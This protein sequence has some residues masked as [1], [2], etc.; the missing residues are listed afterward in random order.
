MGN[1]SSVAIPTARQLYFSPL[2]RDVRSQEQL[3]TNFFASVKLSNGTYKY[4]YSNR[5]DDLNALVNPLLPNVRPLKIMDVAISSG[6]ST[7]EWAESLEKSGI[8]HTLTGGDLTATAI[9]ISMGKYLHVLTDAT[10]YPLQFEVLGKPMPNPPGGRNLLRYFLPLTL[11]RLAVP[12]GFDLAMGRSKWPSKL[13]ITHR[14]IT[15]TSP[16]LQRSSKIQVVDDDILN[17]KSFATSFHVLRAANILNRDY[18]DDSTLVKMLSNLRDRLLPQGVLVV[19]GTND[20]GVNHGS[21]FRL[22]SARH[23]EVLTRLNQGSDIEDLVLGL[24]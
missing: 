19:C 22:D 17:N 4:T 24:K 3:E 9:L 16:R 21:V 6:M 15:L 11:L 10:G 13:G 18:F 1:S 12:I 20:D 7:F 23:F 5:L 2:Q 14:R 8:D